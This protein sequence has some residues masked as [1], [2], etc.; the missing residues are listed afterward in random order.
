MPSSTTFTSS[1]SLPRTESYLSRCAMVSID[2]RS[3]TATKSMSAPACLAAREKFRPMRPKP[4]IPT[5]TVMA[6]S[7]PRGLPVVRDC[8]ANPTGR[9]PTSVESRLR[10]A[11]HVAMLD[12]G[13]V[14][15]PP[16]PAGQLLGHDHRPGT[17]ARA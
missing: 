9:A 6:L 10:P 2:P 7:F 3:L 5:R 17:P 4:L 1:G 11:L 14:A 13:V 12:P 8:D 15:P 16:Q